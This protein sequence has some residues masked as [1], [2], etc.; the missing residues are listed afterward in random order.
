MRS[1]L[2]D[3]L[4][5]TRHERAV[6]LSTDAVQAAVDVPLKIETPCAGWDL[7]ALLDHMSTQNRG[8]AAA[9]RGAQDPTVWEVRS[10]ADPIDDYLRSANEVVAAVAESDAHTWALPEIPPGRFPAPIALGFHLIDSVVHAWDVARSIGR[11]IDLDHDLAPTA[12]SIAEAV[13]AG[14]SR[15][16]PDAAFAPA[17]DVT[18]LPGGLVNQPGQAKES[19]DA[20]ATLDRILRLLGRSPDWTPSRP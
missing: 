15:L 16:R 11:S 5:L 7:R 1:I 6:R 17:L 18:N 20:A 8:F 13:P 10:A 14:A 12:L 19:I 3:R 2:D 9:A 4:L